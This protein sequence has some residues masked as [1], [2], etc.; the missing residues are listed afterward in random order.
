[1]QVIRSQE[2]NR[3][4]ACAKLAEIAKVLND[5]L[6]SVNNKLIR[7]ATDGYDTRQRA[8]ASLAN[9]QT[10]GLLCAD[11]VREAEALLRGEPVEATA[12]RERD[13]QEKLSESHALMGMR[14]EGFMEV[15]GATERAQVL[16]RAI[17]VSLGYM[18]EDDLEA[19]H[20]ELR[21]SDRQ[22]RQQPKVTPNRTAVKRR[23]V[24]KP[25]PF[26]IIEGG[27]TQ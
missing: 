23:P 27:Y 2:E 7:L 22:K 5:S 9:Y 17:I 21:E 12:D 1:M 20:Q 4:A 11:D 25:T 15:P 14:R 19:L 26:R 8:I 18:T 24:Q 13:R 3:R 16:C 6:T 10:T